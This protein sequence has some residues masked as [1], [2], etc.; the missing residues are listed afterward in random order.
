MAFMPSDPLGQDSLLQVRKGG[1]VLTLKIL[2][3][4][5]F[6]DEVAARRET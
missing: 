2:K 5:N 1:T 6:M 3:L 4:H